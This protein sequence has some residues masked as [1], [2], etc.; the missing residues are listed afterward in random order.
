MSGFA[1]RSSSASVPAGKSIL[2]ATITRIAIS[3]FIKEL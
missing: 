2:P 3:L 1:V